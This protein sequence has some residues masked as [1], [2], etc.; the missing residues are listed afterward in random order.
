M[1]KSLSNVRIITE[2]IL[3]I[4]LTCTALKA[5]TNDTL[6]PQDVIPPI[7]QPS[8]IPDPVPSPP[9]PPEEVLPSPSIPIPSDKVP[10]SETI[11]VTEFEFIGNTVL[12]SEQLIERLD[13]KFIQESLPKTFS[14]TELLEI[15]ADVAAFYGEKGYTTS[16]AIISI[17]EATRNQ[18]RGTVRIKVIEGKLEE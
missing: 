4:L 2:T 1:N 12:S 5:Q 17:P 18:Q 11:T 8:P 6:P 3:I 10:T 7:P 14:L 16:G 9:P 15:A 13:N